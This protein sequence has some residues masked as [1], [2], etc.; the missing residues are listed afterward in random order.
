[1]P[2]NKAVVSQDFGLELGLIFAR[3]LLNTEDLHY[4]YW[5][6][7]L[8]V[9]LENLPAAQEAYTDFLLGH[10]PQRPSAILEVG[11]GAGVTAE[12]LL[13]LGHDVECVSPPSE[14]VERAKA[15]LGERV[16]IHE[17][18]F[19]DLEHVIDP[20]GRFDLV[21]FSESFQYVRCREGLALAKSL[22][23]P[24]GAILVC[25]FFKRTGKHKSIIGGGHKIHHLT[26]FSAQVGLEI[27]EDVDITDRTA[28]TL[29]LVNEFFDKAGKP[30]YD[31]AMKAAARSYPLTTRIAK[32]FFR[33]RLANMERKYFTGRRTGKEFAETKTYRLFI[34]KPSN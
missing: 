19:E 31:A 32:W 23:K 15:R 33:K 22:L 24:G 9:K 26:D 11:C 28:P 4:G 8:E 10:V 21:M 7:G 30:A 17:M 6:P 14:L 29:D 13:A 3:Y 2:K 1:M 20:D 25:D 27:A 18:G 12:K 16:K 34:L 5:E